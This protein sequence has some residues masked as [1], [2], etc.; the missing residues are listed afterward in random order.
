MCS[1]EMYDMEDSLPR[2]RSQLPKYKRA[3]ERAREAVREGWTM[4]RLCGPNALFGT[5][6]PIPLTASVILGA[7]LVLKD[8]IQRVSNGKRKLGCSLPGDSS[9]EFIPHWYITAT[10]LLAATFPMVLGL[11]TCM[12]A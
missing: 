12:T 7:C 2:V 6:H 8:K 4:Q 10:H 1:E 11:E 9:T 3:V 5:H